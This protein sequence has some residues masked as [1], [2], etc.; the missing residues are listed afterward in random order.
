MIDESPDPAAIRWPVVGL[1]ALSGGWMLVDGVRALITGDYA[2]IDGELGPWADL[3]EQTTSIDAQGT[4]MKIGFVAYGAAQLIAAAGYADRRRWG[5]P[6]V[7]TAAAGSLWY[8]VLGTAAG[9]VQLV[10]LIIGRRA[11]SAGRAGRPR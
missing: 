7:A 5:R 10:L 11:R 1:A 8:L 2:R 4:P 9:L 3:V 6:A